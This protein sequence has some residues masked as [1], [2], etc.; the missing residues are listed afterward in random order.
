MTEEQATAAMDGL[1][2]SHRIAP[3]HLRADAFDQF[4]EQRR[5]EL[6]ELISQVIGKTIRPEQPPLTAEDALEQKDEHPEEMSS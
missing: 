4:Y 1:L 6:L 3:E 2:R 5:S